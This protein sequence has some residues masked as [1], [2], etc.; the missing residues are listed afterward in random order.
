MKRGGRW[1]SGIDSDAAPA[2][3][4]SLLTELISGVSIDWG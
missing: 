2:S 1:G 3:E 4:C